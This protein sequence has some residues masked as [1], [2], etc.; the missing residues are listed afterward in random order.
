[1]E[2]YKLEF[3]TYLIESEPII[4]LFDIN[5]INSLDSVSEIKMSGFRS[6]YYSDESKMVYLDID[7]KDGYVEYKYYFDM[8]KKFKRDSIINGILS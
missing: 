1:M 5:K 3:K 4:T 6:F 8:V 2:I 7:F